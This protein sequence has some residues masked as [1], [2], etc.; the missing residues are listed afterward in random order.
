MLCGVAGDTFFL[1]LLLCGVA[2]AEGSN[3][4]C[5]HSLCVVWRGWCCVSAV[6]CVALRCG[7]VRCVAV[8]CG[9]VRFGLVRCGA[10]RCG[11]VWCGGGLWHNLPW[12]VGTY[13]P[14]ACVCMRGILAGQGRV[15]D[16]LQISRGHNKITGFDRG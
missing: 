9:A 4:S 8:R 10:V 7:A 13:V 15:V 14:C 3:P 12:L 16:K 6:R 5:S 1:F 2:F 11:A